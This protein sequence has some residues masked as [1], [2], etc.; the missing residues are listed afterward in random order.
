MSQPTFQSIS[1]FL[2]PSH[3]MICEIS[4]NIKISLKRLLIFHCEC[5]YAWV[6]NAY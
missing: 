1:G 4:K 3:V 2:R 6:L 5:K